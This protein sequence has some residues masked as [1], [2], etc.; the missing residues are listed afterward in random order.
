MALLIASLASGAASSLL[1]SA[2]LVWRQRKFTAF[3]EKDLK[4]QGTADCIDV[5]NSSNQELL[6]SGMLPLA[7]ALAPVLAI[8]A[9]ILA[10]N[11]SLSERWKTPL[12]LGVMVSLAITALSLFCAFQMGPTYRD[13]NID[14]NCQKNGDRW[15]VLAW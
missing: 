15:P 10:F 5:C 2:L 8:A 11:V 9:L 12:I 3:C 1:P 7:F 13:I 14:H 6:P 4:K